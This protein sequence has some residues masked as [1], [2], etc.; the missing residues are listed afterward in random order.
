MNTT[1]TTC[2]SVAL[3]SLSNEELKVLSVLWVRPLGLRSERD[4]ARQ[5]GLDPAKALVVLQ[6]LERREMVDHREITIAEGRAKQVRVWVL[7]IIP[8][9]IT[10]EIASA[11]H[12]NL[13]PNEISKLMQGA[14]NERVPAR[15]S[16]LF[17][18]A[19]LSKLNLSDHAVSIAQSV[20]EHYDVEALS[21]AIRSI[22]AEAFT[23]VANQKRGCNP[24]IRKLAA[25]IAAY[26]ES[27]LIH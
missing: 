24:R 9:W 2:A 1:E 16:H 22:P 25:N 12:A 11:I 7:R 19:D 5:A 14:N 21:W 18:N 15:F 13:P 3:S 23:K 8:N 20:L 4:V 27:C 6:E 10:E 17:W 26:K